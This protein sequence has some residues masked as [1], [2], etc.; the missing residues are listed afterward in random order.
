MTELLSCRLFLQ[1][2]YFTN[3]IEEFFI[4]IIHHNFLYLI[5]AEKNKFK[6]EANFGII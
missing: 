6:F 5:N 2:S 1:F 4:L 3:L